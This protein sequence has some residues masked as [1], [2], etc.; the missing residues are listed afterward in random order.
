ML[1]PI[2]PDF[3]FHFWEQSVIRNIA[4]VLRLFEAD[5][6]K[7][8]DR[9]WELVFRRCNGAPCSPSRRWFYHR[10][11]FDLMSPSGR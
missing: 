8:E 9:V 3:P 10:N 1:P 2:L 5:G 4:I 7:A 6:A 11:F